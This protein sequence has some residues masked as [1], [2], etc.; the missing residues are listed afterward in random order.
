MVDRLLM[1]GY[2]EVDADDV[3]RRVR[4]DAGVFL[5][6]D[7]GAGLAGAFRES[8]VGPLKQVQIVFDGHVV[9]M[10][11]ATTAG[12]HGSQKLFTCPKGLVMILGAH[13][14]LTITAGEGGLTTTAQIVAAIGTAAAA[15]DNATLTSTE[16]DIVASTAMTLVAGTD[17]ETLKSTDTEMPAIYDGTSTAKEVFLNFAAADAQASDDD[18]LTVDGTVTVTYLQMGPF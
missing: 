4:R 10:T 2:V 13:A 14:L 9:T 12:I 11:D 15:T 16:A 5:R 17:T 18:T 6:S 1:D 7:A 3:I 8:S